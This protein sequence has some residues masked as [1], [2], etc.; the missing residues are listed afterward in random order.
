MRMPRQT[1]DY[2]YDELKAMDTARLIHIMFLHFNPDAGES[3]DAQSST[4]YCCHMILE[5]RLA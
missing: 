1:Y 4:Y 5:E 2:D 3:V